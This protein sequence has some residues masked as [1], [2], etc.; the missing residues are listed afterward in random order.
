MAEAAAE[1]YEA[2][3]YAAWA[4]EI[5]GEVF[6]D[7]LA[8]TEAGAA[9]EKW[10]TL[11][12]LERVTGERMATVLRGRNVNIAPPKKSGELLAAAQEYARMSFA[13]AVASMRPIL[14]NAI[15]KFEALLAQ[16]PDGERDA[17]QF[18]VDHER[19]LLSFVDLETEQAGDAALND[20]RALIAKAKRATTSP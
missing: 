12:E 5:Q 4:G 20:V 6:F 10:E 3:V 11:A 19:A 14:V 18:L 8:K 17:M 1:G 9:R 7:A 2:G 16:A 13:D 15:G